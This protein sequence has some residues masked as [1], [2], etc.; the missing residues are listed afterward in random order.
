[1]GGEALG[2]TPNRLVEASP[3]TRSPSRF[4]G[5]VVGL[6]GR[7]ACAQADSATTSMLT[8]TWLVMMS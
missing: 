3:M 5:W 1:V 4:G 6:S 8:G 2:K 7:D